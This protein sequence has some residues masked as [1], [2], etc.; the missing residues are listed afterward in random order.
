[1]IGGTNFAPRVTPVG[2]FATG[3]DYFTG[4]P[5][6]VNEGGRG[7]IINL[8]SGSQII[9]HD[10]SIQQAALG[11]GKKETPAINLTLIIQGNVIGNDE[12][13]NQCGEGIVN[14]IQMALENM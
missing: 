5:A 3:T 14:R 9:P 10:K 2:S 6:E 4:G 11:F 1:G 8:P 7:E 12:F 13:I